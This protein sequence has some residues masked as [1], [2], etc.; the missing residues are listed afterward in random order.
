MRKF[1]PV[2]AV[3]G[4]VLTWAA[5]F[6]AIRYCLRELAPLPLASMR[7]SLAAL[8]ALIWLAWFRP[9]LPSYRDLAIIAFCG[10]LGIAAYN[11]LLNSGQT[12]V[13]PGAAS[14]IVNTQPLFMV[15]LAFFFLGEKQN[16]WGWLGAA[17][18]FGGVALIAS[19]QPG[20]LSFG[21]GASLIVG[22]ALC[23]AIFS[24][25]QRP[26]LA[27]LGALQ[28][29]SL[30]IVSGALVLTPWLSAGVEATRQASFGTVGVLVFL[31]LAPAWIGQ[32]CWSYA[33][34]AYG[35]ARA[36]LFLFLIPPCAILISWLFLGE[37]PE[38]VTL[39]GG[40]LSISGVALVNT[41]G[42]R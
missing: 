11:M 9:K 36:G 34:K 39:A 2:F 23:A 3:A 37:R 18:G 40:A 28:V 7:F 42:R 35:A 19:G 15:L 20:G 27:R 33:I 10:A 31:A 16:P 14:F 17:L 41:L 25:L 26:L 22:A 6:P 5:A 1:L 29:T 13:S 24:V 38:L 21:M 8:V 30:A 32:I 12:T 4:T